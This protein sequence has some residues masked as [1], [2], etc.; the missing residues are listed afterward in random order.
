MTLFYIK[1]IAQQQSLQKKKNL[2]KEKK[3]STEQHGFSII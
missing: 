2:K 3:L 1:K